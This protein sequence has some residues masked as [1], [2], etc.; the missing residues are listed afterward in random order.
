VVIKIA[1]IIIT[2]NRKHPANDD[3]DGENNA[4]EKNSNKILIFN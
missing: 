3:V 2:N 1:I 4:E